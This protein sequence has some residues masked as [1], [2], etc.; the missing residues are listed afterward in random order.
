MKKMGLI[1]C[2]VIICAETPS[3]SSLFS[4]IFYIYEFH[5]IHINVG[6]ARL[7]LA[8]IQYTVSV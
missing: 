5:K 6:N 4:F 7:L 2:D 1:S 3:V 8:L